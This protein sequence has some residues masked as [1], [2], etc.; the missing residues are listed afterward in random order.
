MKRKNRRS[1]K[2]KQLRRGS[3]EVKKWLMEDRP[4]CDI[5]GSTQ[6]LELHHIY[7]IRHG[8]PTALQHCT[9]LCSNC[10]HKFHQE[11]DNLLDDLNRKNHSTDFLALYSDLIREIKVKCSQK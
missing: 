11:F 4:Y 6:N 2:N 9:L 5:C 8:F 10:H 3:R 7:L 1:N